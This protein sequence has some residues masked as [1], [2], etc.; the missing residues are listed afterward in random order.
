MCQEAHRSMLIALR[1]TLN[2]SLNHNN[3]AKAKAKVKVK[4]KKLST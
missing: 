4:V 1:S 2:L 3:K